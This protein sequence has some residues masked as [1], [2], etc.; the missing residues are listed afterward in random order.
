M[1]LS[2]GKEIQITLKRNDSLNDFQS[3]NFEI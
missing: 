3:E 2:S 1:A